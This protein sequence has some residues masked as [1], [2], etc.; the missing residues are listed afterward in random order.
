MP[1]YCVAE[2]RCEDGQTLKREYGC[3]C[4][5]IVNCRLNIPKAACVGKRTKAK[6]MRALPNVLVLHL[7]AKYVCC[8][9]NQLILSVCVWR[10][11][12]AA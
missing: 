2:L 11:K 12:G 7:A 8:Y 6:K 4:Y 1:S 3:V 9:T 5:V 10:K